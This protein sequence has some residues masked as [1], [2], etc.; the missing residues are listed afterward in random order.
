MVAGSDIGNGFVA[1]MGFNQ[2]AAVE[3]AGFVFARPCF[4]AVCFGLGTGFCRVS[5]KTGRVAKPAFCSLAYL[6]VAVRI[7]KIMAY[8]AA[9]DVVRIPACRAGIGL[10]GV[11]AVGVSAV[12][13]SAAALCVF[14]FFAF[15][16]FCRAFAPCRV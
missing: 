15:C 13:M 10:G 14:G 16:R 1:G 4:R 8:P 5:A 2:C 6:P 7:G 12:G 11:A 3:G 9:R